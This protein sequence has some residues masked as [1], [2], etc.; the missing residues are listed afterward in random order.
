MKNDLIIPTPQQGATAGSL[1]SGQPKMRAQG[2]SKRYGPTQA[3]HP[4]DL[5]VRSGELLTLLGPSG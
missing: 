3:L 2:L 1:E 4:V 5:D